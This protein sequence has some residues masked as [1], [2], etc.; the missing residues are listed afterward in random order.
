MSMDFLERL[1]IVRTLPNSCIYDNLGMP[2]IRKQEADLATLNN[3]VFIN[4]Q[5][6][7]TTRSHPNSLVLFFCYDKILRR[8]WENPLKY[9]PLLQL[10]AFCCTPDFSIYPEMN[11]W[12]IAHNTFKNRWLG[13]LWQS[14]GIKVICSIS[15]AGKDT[16][17]ICF[18]GIE[19]GSII[20]V[21][22]LGC[23]QSNQNTFLNGY[24]EMMERVEPSIVIV[25]GTLIDGMFGKIMSINYKDCFYERNSSRQLFL[26][27]QEQIVS[28]EKE[29]I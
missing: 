2:L 25:Y 24:R 8:Y 4:A 5:N 15:W 16:Y 28:I 26:F 22:T 10:S 18:S 21:S 12:E 29:I 19:K 27:P 14:Y 13:C 11:I 3:T 20:A 7:I 6:L 9:I 1:K 17:D 23:T